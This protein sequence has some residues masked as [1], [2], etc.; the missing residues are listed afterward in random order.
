[1]KFFCKRGMNITNS[2]LIPQG[3]FT[4]NAI[5]HTLITTFSVSGTCNKSTFSPRPVS[6]MQ[7]NIKAKCTS[8]NLHQ[9]LATMQ[10]LYFYTYPN[11]ENGSF[12]MRFT[13]CITI[14]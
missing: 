13:L 8:I 1:M 2:N 5:S 4:I 10:N 6:T 11:F 9:K 14:A 7:K 3:N 12:H